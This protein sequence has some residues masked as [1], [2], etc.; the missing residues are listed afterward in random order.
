MPSVTSGKHPS[1][2]RPVVSALPVQPAVSGVASFCTVTVD[3]V[4]L[5]RKALHR[6]TAAGARSAMVVQKINRLWQP[7]GIVNVFGMGIF[8]ISAAGVVAAGFD[9]SLPFAGQAIAAVVGMA[10]GIRAT[11]SA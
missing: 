2:V 5:T 1:P 11:L 6:H 9:A 10:I 7:Q 8:M 4:V 3:E